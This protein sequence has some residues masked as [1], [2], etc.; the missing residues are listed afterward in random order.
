MAQQGPD[1]HTEGKEKCV[2]ALETRVCHLGRIKGCCLDLQMWNQ[3]SQG[4]GKTEVG[5]GH[6]KQ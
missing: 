1:E 2:Q 5:E 6:E 3:E 4:A